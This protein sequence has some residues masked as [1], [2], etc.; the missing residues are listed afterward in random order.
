MCA[1]VFLFLFLFGTLRRA[2]LRVLLGTSPNKSQ[3]AALAGLAASACSLTN[4][5]FSP[6]SE[7]QSPIAEVAAADEQRPIAS[8]RSKPPLGAGGEGGEGGEKAEQ[9]PAE[10]AAPRPET[11]AAEPGAPTPETG[12]AEPGVPAPETGAADP[13]APLVPGDRPG[14]A[15]PTVGPAPKPPAPELVEGAEKDAGQADASRDSKPLASPS[16]AGVDAG[17]GPEAGDPEAGDPEA[18][19]PEARGEEIDPPGGDLP[20]PSS[21]PQLPSERGLQG[22]AGPA[23]SG[24]EPWALGAPHDA[25]TDAGTDAAASAPYQPR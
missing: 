19:A 24:V 12:A 16:D 9:P 8:P 3:F 6:L 11:G 17:V 15:R 1:I 23:D 2:N 5:E 25:G 21:D 18:G 4:S 22:D 13:G 10:P 14:A 20:I 7:T